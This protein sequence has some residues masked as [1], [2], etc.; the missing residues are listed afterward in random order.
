[1]TYGTAQD[2]ESEQ[3]IGGL[4]RRHMYDDLKLRHSPTWNGFSKTVINPDKLVSFQPN[5]PIK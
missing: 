3:E 2:L 4:L 1:M 5:E